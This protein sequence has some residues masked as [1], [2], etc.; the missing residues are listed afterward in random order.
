[1]RGIGVSGR[2]DLR[3]D[4]RRAVGV[5][6]G[7]LQCGG[8]RIRLFKLHSGRTLRVGQATSGIT[9]IILPQSAR[10][11]HRVRRIPAIGSHA[12][13]AKRRC[14]AVH[15]TVDRTGQ[16]TRQRV[17]RAVGGRGEVVID[18]EIDAVREDDGIVRI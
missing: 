7:V 3:I 2:T 6:F 16:C 18:T 4:L 15:R 13:V 11:D 14:G 10:H 1:M 9:V 12:E 5:S 17:V 8:F